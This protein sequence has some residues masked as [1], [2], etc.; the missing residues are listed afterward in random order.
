MSELSLFCL[1]ELKTMKNENYINIQGWMINELNLKG[2]E[3]VLYSIIYGFSQDDKS[4][5]FGSLSYIEE[6]LKLSRPTV[7]SILNKLSSKGLI[8]KTTESHYKVV[9]KLYQGSK[10]TLLVASKE[11]LPNNNNTN[12]NNK[13]LAKASLLP[14][15]LNTNH[16]PKS[17][18]EFRDVRR[19]EAGRQ[20]MTPKKST[21]KQKAF[22]KRMKSLDYFHKVG[23]EN[24]FD[25][26][27]EEDEQA[28]KKFI[29][30]SRSF[31]KRYGDNFKKLI[32]W[33]FA[34]NNAW[35][36]YH[37]SNFFSIVTW[38]KYDNK[39]TQKYYD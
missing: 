18:K 27:C 33:W 16:K 38:M 23:V 26:L 30:I 25:Y 7:I 29:G 17:Y 4:E 8:I 28:N 12:N 36:D 3:L 13:E 35:C 34:E 22:L 19:M 14:E 5:F 39:K 15:E 6:L 10:E 32:D 24:G 1:L 11:T 9:K 31:E 20:P 21:E 37:P 2:N